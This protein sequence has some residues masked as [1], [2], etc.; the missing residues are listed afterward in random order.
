M[1]SI[2]SAIALILIAM[3]ILSGCS[4]G[5]DTEADLNTITIWHD[6]EDH[7]SAILAEKLAE[8]EPEITVKL[9]RK[10]GLTEALKMV[11]NDPKAAPDLYF[12]AHDKLGV[13][14]AMGILAPITDFLSED[15]LADYLPLTLNA[16]TYQGELYQLPLYF[17]TLLFMYNRR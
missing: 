17:E 8:L 7:V 13:Y 15:E 5:S 14:A 1:K 11:G 9:E 4:G 12:F 6:K 10:E 3:M 2:R 16:A